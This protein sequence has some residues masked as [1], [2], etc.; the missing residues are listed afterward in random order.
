MGGMFALLLLLACPRISKPCTELSLEDCASAPG[1]SLVTG[2]SATAGEDC[3]DL[4]RSEPVA[5]M[6]ARDSCGFFALFAGPGD[7]TCF[8]LG[9]AC[10]P[11]GWGECSFETD[12]GSLCP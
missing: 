1:C 8:R 7:G 12:T 10:V 6:S 11:E 3:T 4:G 9:G 5:C 2:Q